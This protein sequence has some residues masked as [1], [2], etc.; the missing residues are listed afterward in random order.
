MSYLDTLNH[1]L[2][3]TPPERVR[4]F[5]IWTGTKHRHVAEPLEPLKEAL[6][7]A[8]A[9]L[10]EIYEMMLTLHDIEHIPTAYRKNI[11][12]KHNA[13][14]HQHNPY[15]YRFDFSNFYDTITITDVAR[16]LK[17]VIPLSHEAKRTLTQACIDPRTKGLTQGSPASGTLAGIALIPFWI[18]LSK[19]LPDATITQYSDDLCISSQT[20]LDVLHL[21]HTIRT[22]LRQCNLRCVINTKKTRAEHLQ[23][24]RLTGVSCNADNQLTIRREDYRSMRAILHALEKAQSSHDVSTMITTLEDMSLD[25]RTLL[26]QWTFYRYIDTSGKIAHLLFRYD[27]IIRSLKLIAYP[28]MTN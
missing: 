20:P 25:P 26:G 16:A 21:I 2:V 1:A 4:H 17:G 10:S 8:N 9:E 11:S 19:K 15:W 5:A 24:R 22:T 12:V 18:A 14:A 3:L 6:T 13:Q 28:D 27:D 23:Y 7:Q